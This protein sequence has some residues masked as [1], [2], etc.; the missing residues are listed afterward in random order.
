MDKIEELKDEQDEIVREA[1]EIVGNSGVIP[2]CPLK[3]L[4]S[5]V[6]GESGDV[7]QVWLQIACGEKRYRVAIDW[8]SKQVVSLEEL[9]DRETATRICSKK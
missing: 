5:S 7:E 8:R 3:L 4:T 2:R 6:S 1:L 9:T